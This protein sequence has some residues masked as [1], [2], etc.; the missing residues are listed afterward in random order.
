MKEE[1]NM[2]N[3]LDEVSGNVNKDGRDINVIEKQIQVKVGVGSLIF[4]II[5]W[6]VGIIPGVVFLFM[7]IKARN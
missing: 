7:K 6:V 1:N 2:A 3:E 5:L 4:E